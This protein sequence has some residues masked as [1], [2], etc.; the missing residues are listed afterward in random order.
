MTTVLWCRSEDGFSV[1][2]Q[3]VETRG[4]SNNNSN[5]RANL[6][7]IL[8]CMRHSW[9][10]PWPPPSSLIFGDALKIIEFLAFKLTT[11]RVHHLHRIKKQAKLDQWEHEPLKENVCFVCL[12]DAIWAGEAR[13]QNGYLISEKRSNEVFVTHWR[14]DIFLNK[15]LTIIKQ[16]K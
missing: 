12:A 2:E 16:L 13:E 11:T 6:K 3:T 5:N 9:I 15:S 14:A 4:E 10:K 7:L 8:I 1:F